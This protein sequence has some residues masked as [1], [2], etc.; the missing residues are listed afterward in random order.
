MESSDWLLLLCSNISASWIWEISKADSFIRYF[1]QFLGDYHHWKS[2]PQISWSC[3][4]YSNS[5][6][7][8]WFSPLSIQLLISAQVMN[9]ELW[10]WAPCQAL[11]SVQSLLDILSPFPL[12]LA[13]AAHFLSNIY[14]CSN[15]LLT[16]VIPPAFLYSDVFAYLCS[17][18]GQNPW[19]LSAI[20]LG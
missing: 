16:F 20:F 15:W 17:P 8:G 4:I 2:H 5:G 1:G 3:Q 10:D 6:A 12:L 14:F 18:S 11:C 13:P 9:S 19:Q 7:F